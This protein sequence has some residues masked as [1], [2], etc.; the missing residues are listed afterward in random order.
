MEFTIIKSRPISILLLLLLLLSIPY[1]STGSFDVSEKE[2]YE[3]DYRGPETH[4]SIPPPGH[5]HRSSVHQQTDLPTHELRSG[6]KI[7][8]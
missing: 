7:H 4:T 8:G 1:F 5:G 2:V 3:I 6:N